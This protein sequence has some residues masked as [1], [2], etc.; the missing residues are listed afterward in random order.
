VTA[1]PGWRS[2]RSTGSTL[3]VLALAATLR[4]SAT[5]AAADPLD[6]ASLRNAEY[7][8]AWTASRRVR[9]RDGRYGA[10][11]APGSAA[12]IRVSLLDRRVVW[13]EGGAR[14]AAVILVTDPGGSG[15]FYQL[16][17][18]EDRRGRPVQVASAELADRVRV[19][20]LGLARREGRT[21][22]HV[23][24]IAHAPGDPLCCPTERA[25]RAF[26][27]DGRSL[28]SRAGD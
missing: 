15:T 7:G 17:V 11:A 18:V 16:V 5:G 9:L 19:E 13:T 1:R 8:S 3:L 23:G 25:V 27:W 6:L 4:F 21:E 10:P 22:L 14:Y 24:L 20:S 12:E 26:V 2:A 28:I